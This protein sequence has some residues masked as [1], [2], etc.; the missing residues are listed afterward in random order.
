MRRPVG[1]KRHRERVAPVEHR[2]PRRRA[3]GVPRRWRHEL[4]ARA[5][6]VAR[7][8]GEAEVRVRAATR[9][10]AR[11]AGEVVDVR[12]RASTSGRARSRTTRCSPSLSGER[13]GE[14]GVVVAAVG[15]ADAASG[16]PAPRRLHEVDAQAGRQPEG[17]RRRGLPR[18]AAARPSAMSV[19]AVRPTSSAARAPGR[20]ARLAGL[21]D[22]GLRRVVRGDAAARESRRARRSIGSG[23]GLRDRAARTRS[24]SASAQRAQRSVAPEPHRLLA[25]RLRAR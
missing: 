8:G 4:R 10:A 13:P 3:A 22:D 19:R 23:I 17:Q 16:R 2:Q 6:E 1:R 7:D 9:G 11:D 14:P 21:S 24:A 18:V 25:P 15:E 20:N 12:V 5:V